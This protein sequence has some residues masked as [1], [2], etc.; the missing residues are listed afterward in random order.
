MYCRG[1]LEF[2]RIFT[3]LMAMGAAVPRGMKHSIFTE[4]GAGSLRCYLLH[5]L[6]TPLF[7]PHPFVHALL[8]R[9]ENKFIGRGRA[10]WFCHEVLITAYMVGVQILISRPVALP[11]VLGRLPPSISSCWTRLVGHRFFEPL[12]QHVKLLCRY[13]TKCASRVIGI[14]ARPGQRRFCG[15][16]LLIC[17]CCYGS[18][19]SLLL[20]K[21]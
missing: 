6:V 15:C 12:E 13:W 11:S 1:A 2:P 8:W 3:H 19:W 21:S 20:P 5:V 7:H 4:T 16:V 17:G 9:F 14:A 10:A 18:I